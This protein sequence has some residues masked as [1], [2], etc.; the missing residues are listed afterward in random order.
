M[1]NSESKTTSTPSTDF[2]RWVGQEV[3]KLAALWNEPMGGLRLTGYV[4]RLS[5]LQPDQLREAFQRAGDELTK[6]PS[7]AELRAL[8]GEATGK[9]AED[10]EAMAAWDQAERY[11][12][13]WGVDLLPLG[14]EHAPLLPPRIDYALRRIGGLRGLNQITEERRAFMMRDFMQGFKD[15]TVAE[16]KGLLALPPPALKQQVLPPAHEGETPVSFPDV[17]KQVAEISQAKGMPEHERKMQELRERRPGVTPALHLTKEQI[18]ARRARAL[19]SKDAEDHQRRLHRR[20]SPSDPVRRR[21][22]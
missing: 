15:A 16:A 7:V 8:A 11:L 21:K 17:M 13:K 10:V 1:D 19:D 5:D 12:R 20:Q 4:E 18:E 14:R 2:F 3:T 6:M 9:Q 22:L